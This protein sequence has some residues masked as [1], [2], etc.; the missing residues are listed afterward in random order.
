MANWAST[1]Y[2]IEGNQKDL[3]ELNDLCKAFMNKERPVMEEGASENW[4][5]NIIL[6]LG[7][8]IG[9]SYIRGFIQYLELSDDLLSIEAEEAW[10]ATDFNKLLEKHYD[11]MKVYFIVEEE[12]C[13]VYATN[14]AEGKYFNCRSILTSYV[15]GEYHREEFKN[16]NEALKYAAKL[17]GRDSVTILE[18]GKWNMEHEDNNEYININGFDLVD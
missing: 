18:V 5:G 4:E 8:E 9:D 1:S 7:E 13:E 16:K 6:A 14:D 12:M 10:G 17:L 15:E 11:G 2:R 3:Q